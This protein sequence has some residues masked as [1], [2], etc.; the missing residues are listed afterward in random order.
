M[1]RP[2]LLLAAAHLLA[3]SAC[4]AAAPGRIPAPPERPLQPFVSEQE[5]TEYRAWQ[6]QESEQLQRQ[7]PPPPMIIEHPSY[8]PPM[9]RTPEGPVQSSGWSVP[10]PAA[11][12]A[13]AAPATS[14]ASSAPA[15][16]AASAAPTAPATS[17]T[18]ATSAVSA[19]STAPAAPAAPTFVQPAEETDPG[20]LARVHGDFLVMVHRGRLV[21]V[22]IGAGA[23]EPVSVVD[24][25]NADIQ[26]LFAE[27]DEM[28]ISGDRVVLV[29]LESVTSGGV[30][31][32]VF[33]MAANGT[34]THRASYTMASAGGHSNDRRMHASRLVGDQLVFYSALLPDHY[35]LRESS[36]NDFPRINRVQPG[37]YTR[38]EPEAPTRV[39]RPARGSS[40]GNLHTVT[41]CALAGDDL[42]CRSTA[43]YG[44]R[45]RP[46][47]L[48]GTAVYLWTHQQ[49]RYWEENAETRHVLYRLPFDGSA[50]TAL[51]VAG[52]PANAFSLHESADGHVNVLVRKDRSGAATWG[53]EGGLALLRVPLAQL[54]DGG[55]A[56]TAAQ[57][58]PLPWDAR[59]PLQTR[60]AGD[61][62]VYGSGDFTAATAAQGRDSSTAYAVHVAGGEVAQIALQHS[63]DRIEPLGAG[64]VILGGKGPDLHVTT[65]RLD[66][67]GAA[68][69]AHHRIPK[70]RE[71][72]RIARGVFAGDIGDGGSVL[73][74]PMQEPARPGA[75]FPT[76]GSAR[77]TLLR[78]DGSHLEPLG[79]V[80]S[81][82][83]DQDDGCLADCGPWFGNV[84]P[85]FAGGRILALMGYELVEASVAGGRL[86]EVR[87]V[88]FTPR[89]PIETLAGD[90]EFTER[91]GPE[92][93]P[94][95]CRNAGT[96]RLD[97]DGRAIALRYR[98]TG[99]CTVNGVTRSTDGEG[100]GTGTIG[101]NRFTLT[102]NGCSYRARMRSADAF[103]ANV[104]C[105]VAEPGSARWD[106][107]GHLEARRVRP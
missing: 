102:V 25:F 34:L 63:A 23:L 32:G 69:A 8:Y 10:E 98:Q 20:P 97:R 11:S 14:A 27:Y 93:G 76:L 101:D 71:G 55:S 39:Y 30:T 99:E 36:Y 16:S 28:L 22:R 50:P 37:R 19:T 2:P 15:V 95:R 38:V 46:F 84:R 54:G 80:E 70:P 9:P 40:G 107:E 90:W 65:L 79:E 35:E 74:L 68:A 87:R 4:A 5:W 62:L 47:Y 103:I 42:R 104:T 105:P 59:G 29:N 75:P 43:L 67:A 82:E 12:S 58:R 77:I 1:L 60:F 85:V 53:T 51:A 78:D 61:W 92:V 31:L 83:A 106:V 17:A 89:A 13:P 44:P 45:A 52:Q 21:T 72:L 100:S 7:A 26:T 57:Y 18:S 49:D 41:S 81:G 91:L 56:A 96:L 33:H 24:A 6:R 88:A 3:L 73:A 66:A 64:A 94:Y 48:S 86:R